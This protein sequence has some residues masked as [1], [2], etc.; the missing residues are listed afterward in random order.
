[1]KKQQDNPSCPYCPETFTQNQRQQYKNHLKSVHAAEVYK[2]T[3]C[4]KPGK[5][6]GTLQGHLKT[7]N[8]G[9]Y[10]LSLDESR[11]KQLNDIREQRRQRK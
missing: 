4:G 7:H 1:M 9:S 2:C 8:P 6:Y 5:N 11:R 10:W 3:I